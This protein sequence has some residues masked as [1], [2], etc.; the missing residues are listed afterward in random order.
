MDVINLLVS[1]EN[2]KTLVNQYYSWCK[3]GQK[4]N[5]KALNLLSVWSERTCCVC[6]LY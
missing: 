1:T 6:D 3:W 5:W 4:E 2:F